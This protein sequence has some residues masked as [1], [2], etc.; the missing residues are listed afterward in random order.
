MYVYQL[1]R[2]QES[3]VVLFHKFESCNAYSIHGLEIIEFQ[4][5]GVFS[6]GLQNFNGHYST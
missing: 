3:C 4:V 6:G 2:F 5:G 1:D